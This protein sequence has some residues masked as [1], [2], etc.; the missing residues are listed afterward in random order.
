MVGAPATQEGELG[1]GAINAPRR[2]R[3]LLGGILNIAWPEFERIVSQS[4]DEF[5]Q[6]LFDFAERGCSAVE[7]AAWIE[8]RQLVRQRRAALAPILRQ[9]LVAELGRIREPSVGD[10]AEATAG[11][12]IGV[13]TEFALSTHVDVDEASVLVQMSNRVEMRNNLSLFLLGQ[14]FGVLA[15]KPGLGPESI[16]IGPRAFGRLLRQASD[17]LQLSPQHR[18]LFFK[19]TE[20][21]MMVGYGELIEVANSFLIKNGILPDFGYMPTRSRPKSATEPPP[22]PAPRT[23]PAAFEHSTL[24]FDPGWSDV[25]GRRRD[26]TEYARSQQAEPVPQ[27]LAGPRGRSER[28]V[29]QWALPA[30]GAGLRPPS[31]VPAPATGD[32]VSASD[33][34][35]SFETMRSLLANRNRLLAKLRP[36]AGTAVPPS[37]PVPTSV[38]L[39][40]MRSLQHA[41]LAPAG[42]GEARVARSIQGIRQELMAR[43]QATADD[44]LPA[45]IGQEDSDVIELVAMLFEHIGRETRLNRLASQ[46]LEKLQVPMLRVALEEKRFFGQRDHPA[47]HLL[48]AIAE[49]AAYWLGDDEPDGEL[50][51]KM[52]SVVDRTV[53]E[54]DGDVALLDQLSQDINSHLHLLTH[55]AEVAE[56]RHVEAARGKEKLAHARKQAADRVAALLTDTRLPMLTKASLV[57]AWTD[58]LALTLLRHGEGTGEWRHQLELAARLVKSAEPPPGGTRLSQVEALGLRQELE[59][60]LSQVGY[61]SD[62]IEAM[63]QALINPAADSPDN[64]MQLEK[65]LKSRARFGDD[66]KLARENE[67]ALGEEAK[68]FYENL[69]SV[70]FGSWFEFVSNQQGDRVR[71]RLAWFSTT[72]GHSLFVNKRGQKVGEYHLATLARRMAAGEVTLVVEKSGGIIENAW[73]SVLSALRGF[74]G[75][76]A[77]GRAGS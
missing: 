18:R 44:G 47:K 59:A 3:F 72:T 39:E 9:G 56:R 50:L 20:K 46:M 10:G 73:K 6:Q 54:F 32:E 53:H 4:L 33:D 71:Q 27:G 19:V 43:L 76:G 13:A 5:E 12:G 51:E 24:G 57:E 67:G 37:R 2:V 22:R 1:F 14:R 23:T 52:N 11:G 31:D 35:V 25:G 17:C 42:D 77:T 16:P 70:P 26:A 30:S 64:S 45:S 62:E 75:P 61:H 65:R 36:G 15:E 21:H 29:P 48:D 69:K 7:E 74:A 38:L 28:A 68:V 49:S 8:T 60:S 40:T 66:S 63:A 41:P 34:Q 55:K 58:V